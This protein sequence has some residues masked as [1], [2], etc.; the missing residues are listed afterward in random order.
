MAKTVKFTYTRNLIDDAEG[1]P[2]ALLFASPESFTGEDVKNILADKD[3]AAL[4]PN[5]PRMVLRYLKPDDPRFGFKQEYRLVVTCLP[6]YSMPLND[7]HNHAV[8]N[9]EDSKGGKVEEIVYRDLLDNCHELYRVNGCEGCDK[10]GAACIKQQLGVEKLPWPY[11]FTSNRQ[12]KWSTGLADTGNLPER[13]EKI[14]KHELQCGTLKD[15][16]ATLETIHPLGG[17]FVAPSE[18]KLVDSQRM[19]LPL[20]PSREHRFFKK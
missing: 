11:L 7:T 10:P 20:R 14:K 8:L 17:D 5:K 9:Y 6:Y 18:T 3:V 4:L 19:N 2:D 13:N 16:N 1:K 15:L 12:D